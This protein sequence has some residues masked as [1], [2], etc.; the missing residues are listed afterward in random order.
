MLLTLALV[1]TLAATPGSASP[2]TVPAVRLLRV[3][4]EHVSTLLRPSLSPGASAPSWRGSGFGPTGAESQGGPSAAPSAASGDGP[5]LIEYS[6]AYFTR[7]TIHKWASFLTLPLFAG[8]YAVG[9]KLLNGSGSDR[10]R[11]V[12]GVLAGSI[13][14]LFAV[15]TVTGGLNAIEAWHDPEG[16]TRRTLHTVLMLAA[17]VG[18]LVTAAT[19]QENENEGGVARTA[20]NTAH[21]NVALA[22]M[23]TALVGI[24]VML[25]IFGR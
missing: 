20:N 12:H 1:G 19:A 25:P 5:Q 14:G 3:G 21:R 17:D 8:Q 6:D 16:R 13:A 24:A 9:R 7:L 23:G 15:N 10:L 22:S 18:F 11:N 4:P 2:D